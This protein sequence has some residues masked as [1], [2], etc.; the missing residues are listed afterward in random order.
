MT[1]EKKQKKSHKKTIAAITLLT[2]FGIIIVLGAYQYQPAIPPTVEEY[3]EVTAAIEPMGN[4]RIEN[5]GT[6]YILHA[7]WVGVKA[8]GGDA[9]GVVV[10]S[11]AGS[12]DLQLGDIPKGQTRSD[13]MVSFTGAVVRQQED[14]NFYVK[15]TIRS[16]EVSGTIERV[17]L[18]A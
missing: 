10:Q 2:V 15:L 14:G 4:D 5:N 17:Y 3:F 12:D 18:P 6:V 13:M 8:V 16:N 1:K 7:I 11:W 9:H